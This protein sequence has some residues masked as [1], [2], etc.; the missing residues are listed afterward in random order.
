MIQNGQS[1]QC[2]RALPRWFLP[3]MTSSTS[4][5]F[6]KKQYFVIFSAAFFLLF[7]LRECCYPLFVIIVFPLLNWNDVSV[8]EPTWRIAAARVSVLSFAGHL[9]RVGR[10]PAG[11]QHT[12]TWCMEGPGHGGAS[13]WGVCIPSVDL[14]WRGE[15]GA[16]QGEQSGPGGW[17]GRRLSWAGPSCKVIEAGCQAGVRSQSSVGGR[18]RGRVTLGLY[19]G[20]KL[21]LIL[22][23]KNPCSDPWNTSHLQK[24]ASQ[25]HL[26]P[27][28][29]TV[30]SVTRINC[31]MIFPKHYF[32]CLLHVSQID[33][34]LPEASWEETGSPSSQMKATS[35]GLHVLGEC[36]GTG[37][38][39]SWV[40]LC[41][42]PC[43]AGF[44]GDPGGGRVECL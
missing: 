7:L 6:I 10:S 11:L 37:L 27:R 26:K 20:I 21:V 25:M 1:S 40:M 36:R 18:D 5:P 28:Q 43:Q 3:I 14:W 32:L 42:G 38:Q 29:R 12:V 35:S 30:S 24:D 22:S 31:K 23:L 39:C 8:S 4:L 33:R 15:P 16:R 2:W 44:A 34:S 9:T 41:F 19:S 17:G 13:G